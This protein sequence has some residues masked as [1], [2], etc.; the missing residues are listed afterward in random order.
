MV[1]DG[2]PALAAP[3]PAGGAP[4]PEVKQIK[5][6]N[7]CL[8]GN[9][10]FGNNSLPTESE[11]M[12][13]QSATFDSYKPLVNNTQQEMN[14]QLRPLLF[15][16]ITNTPATVES[17]QLYGSWST[18]K[19][20]ANAVPSLH[21]HTK[22]RA[23]ENLSYF[24]DGPDGLGLVTNILE[25]PNKQEPVTDWNS[26]SRLFPPV[27]SSDFEN[28]GSFSGLFPI[29]G[30]ENEDC[31]LVGIQKPC[32]ESLEKSSSVE[33]FKKE[34]DD[35][36]V[37][38]SWLATSQ[39]V[40]QSPSEISKSAN[41]ENKAFK[42]GGINHLGSFAYVCN[43][44]KQLNS[45][46]GNTPFSQSRIKDTNAY[47]ECQKTDSAGGVVGRN[48]TEGSSTYFTHL[49]NSADRI[50]GPVIKENNLCPKR[51][52]GFTAAHDS[53]PFGCS[54]SHSLSQALNKENSF[55]DGMNT[56]F[57]NSYMQNI[58][59]STSIV[60]NFGHTESKIPAHPGKGSS[61]Q[62]PLKPD[63]ENMNSSYNGY[64]WLEIKMQSQMATSHVTYGNQMQV[65]SQLSSQ[66][67]AR[68]NGSSTN[69]SVTQPPYSHMSPVV[70]SIKDR[71]Q[72]LFTDV[73]NSSGFSSCTESQKHHNPI[74]HSQ[75][76]SLAST[77]GCYSKMPSNVSS[78]AISQQYSVNHSA[79]YHRFHIKETRYNTDE[80]KGQ[81][82]R[83]CKNNWIQPSGYVNPAPDRTQFDLLRRKQ[84]QNDATLTDC[85]NPTFLPL[86]PLVS[87]YKHVP[88]FSPFSPHPF[89]SPVNA[90]F[91]LLPFPLS[92]LV[93]LLHYEDFPHLSPFINDLCS[94]DLAAPYFAFPPP[95]NHYRPPKNRSGPANELHIHLEEC[96]EQLRALERE[97]KK[98]EADL[99]RNFPGKRV[100]SSSNTPF[101]RLPAKPSRVDRLIVDQFRE[102]ARVY[103]IIEK[104]EHVCGSPVHRNITA[105]LGRHLEA[106]WATQARRKAEIVNSVNPQ[107]QRTSR[108]NNEKGNA[109]LHSVNPC[110]SHVDILALA[111]AIKELAFFT[112]KARTA[113][114]CA[115]QMTLPKTSASTLVKKEEVEKALQELCPANGSFQ[116]NNVMG[117]EGKRNKR[118]NCGE[119][120]QVIK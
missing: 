90:A 59:N 89:S 13:K 50:W 108:Y 74:G 66:P 43:Y 87:G 27:W 44:D 36:Y 23:Q 105:T 103:T 77:E 37:I 39:P 107:R 7:L 35:R 80:R 28:Y 73:S 93:D 113:L 71:K 65:G 72:Q 58:S 2:A 54:S 88:N 33:L 70:S 97:R 104:M 60:T 114:W 62:L 42:N 25:E 21:D 14:T 15:G 102:Q 40:I 38:H 57:Q 55:P 48:G 109:A 118:E 49:P 112:R 83:R 24:G 91:S 92:E 20:D 67:S 110:F 120:Q 45:G 53:G 115:L 47:K 12:V 56:K 51:C 18:C 22:Q 64:T 79:Q 96:Y 81:N 26:L 31:N 8:F 86:F 30:F 78:S 116:T 63:A 29:K 19:D 95:L 98:T 9:A 3:F 75:N 94:G 82:E 34:P 106:I 4:R 111:A 5:T 119:P 11:D 101:S 16:G 41:P 68:S 99:A 100:S 52:T 84:E 46:S 61:N 17:P 117:Y 76:D 69:E 10:Q 1:A 32:E 85:L 6:S